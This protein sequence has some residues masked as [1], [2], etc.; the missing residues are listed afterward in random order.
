M[1]GFVQA[2]P[3]YANSKPPDD[4][5][6]ASLPNAYV[7]FNL[8]RDGTREFELIVRSILDGLHAWDQIG[9]TA[10]SRRKDNHA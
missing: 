5:A 3:R 8:E 9:P 1:I 10:C 2:E 4:R 6:L 7:P